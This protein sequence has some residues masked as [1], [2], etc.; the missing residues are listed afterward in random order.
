M[1]PLLGRQAVVVGAGMAGL[2]AARVL[3]NHF[4]GVVVVENDG[5]PASATPRPG[6]PQSRHAHALLV[7]GQRALGG[8]FS[9]F[10][11]DLL[12]AGATTMRVS[13]DLRFERPG[14]DPF[15]QRD[16]GLDVYS[17]SRPLIE[18]VVRKRVA[19]YN[20]ISLRERC[21]AQEFIG[22]AQTVTAVRCESVDGKSDLLPADLVIDAS[23]HGLLTLHLIES[24]GQPAPPE[25]SIGV[26]IGY[27]TAMFEIP[28]DA[29]SDWKGLITLP[30]PPR[31]RR[32]VFLLPAEGGRWI[33]TLS[34]RY[35]EK[36][37]DDE[38]GYL[39]HAKDLRTP[40][41]HNALRNA[42]RVSDFSRY[43]FK[44]SRRRHFERVDAF[45]VGVIPF[46]DTICRFNPVYGQGMSVASQEACLLQRLLAARAAEGSGIDG[47]A[48]EFFTEV[49]VIIDTPWAG[50]VIPDFLDPL[51][52]GIRPPDLESTLNFS[53][54]L[55]KLAAEDS[56]VHKLVT[57]VQHLLKPQTAY[58]EP[59]LVERVRAVM[60]AHA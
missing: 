22:T 47:L 8:L 18:S 10:E 56:S 20:N 51:T 58:R 52:E 14:Y 49:Q 4:E 46:G 32:G 31:N 44:S 25:T 57:E 6:T 3:A 9:G 41:A 35:H 37:P 23:G 42:K 27:T 33:A 1:S 59:A 39:Q 17:M 7:G 26:D 50:A 15:P 43:G 36:P 24:F 55:F 30:E 21:R 19:A 38:S 11:E 48:R 28:A 40:T 34:G 5:L 60:G 12:Q 29:P 54:A 13:T 16:L 2:A 45:P 53:S